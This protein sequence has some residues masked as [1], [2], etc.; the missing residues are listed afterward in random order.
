MGVT[1]IFAS[2]SGIAEAVS[3]EFLQ[4]DYDIL[5]C[6]RD[7]QAL[8]RQ[9]QD[10][11]VKFNRDVPYMQWDLQPMD[12]HAEKVRSLFEEYHVDGLFMAA[13]VMSPQAECNQDPSK[14]IETMQINLTAVTVILNLFAEQFEQKKTGFISCISSVAGDRGR[15]SNYVYGASKAGL[16]AFL[17]GLRNRLHRHD[18]LVQT[19]KPG[20]VKTKM[21]EELGESI[22]M[23]KPKQVAKEIVDAIER[24]QDI[25][26]TPF[27]WRYIMSTIK[28][29]PE[30]L[31]KRLSL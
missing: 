23:A 27:F 2:T 8:A 17:Q 20:Y 1:V 12:A 30:P 6:A 26:Y 9:A 15:Q 13:G 31:F 24:K 4:R 29:I 28:W 18:V 19:V 7:E 5:L 25:L 11:K 3:E 10:L 14:V 21:T 16:T 22:L